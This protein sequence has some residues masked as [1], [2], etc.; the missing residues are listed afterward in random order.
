MSALPNERPASVYAATRILV[1]DCRETLRRLP[2][3]SVHCVVTSPPYF[4]LRDYGTGR[5]EGGDSTCHHKTRRPA[6]AANGSTLDGGKATTGHQQ[7]GY[8][9][10]CARC[11]ARRVDRQIGLEASVDAY[12]DTLLAVFAEV[13][14]VLRDDGTLWLDMGDSYA[15][16]GKGPTGAHGVG[17]HETRQGFHSPK[18]SAG[19]AKSLMLVPWRLLLALDAAGWT[20]RSVIAWCKAAPMPES[21]TDRPTSAWEPIFL[22]TKKPRYYYDAEAVRQPVAESTVNRG[23]ADF[24]GAKGR[25]Y[26]AAMSPDDPNFR[27]GA[28]Q[29]GRTFDYAACSANGRN[30]WSYWVLG[31]EPYPDAH[32]ATFPT[33]IPRRAVLA[34]TSQK[35]VCPRC[36]KPWQRM[37]QDT[38]NYATFKAGRRGTEGYQSRGL[39]AGNRFGSET[40]SVAR[41]LITTHW[42]PGCRCDAGGPVPATVLDP[43]GG[44]GTTALAANRLGRHAILCELNPRYAQMARERIVAD[45]GLLADVTMEAL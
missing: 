4:A 6:T 25:D 26:Q 34:G 28:E 15:G 13:R 11:G 33:E 12:L 36:G 10:V 21:V 44:A 41:R 3:Q 2:D 31:P 19:K 30:L 5:W 20:V 14:R 18:P 22:L 16:S 9:Q 7:E 24:G 23:P 45:L 17:Q 37:T 35:G 43:F 38:P 8:R 29:W 39:E 27:H 40:P 1:G 32:F 42:Q